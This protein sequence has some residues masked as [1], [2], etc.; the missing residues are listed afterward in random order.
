MWPEMID[1]QTFPENAYK[2]L[3]AG[4]LYL[5]IIPASTQRPELTARAPSY[6]A[7]CSA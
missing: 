7:F 4:E 6:G 5:P 1:T 3:H 2:P